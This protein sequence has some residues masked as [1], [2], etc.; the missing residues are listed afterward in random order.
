MA[1][2]LKPNLTDEEIIAQ[3]D[4]ETPE[5]ARIRIIGE[6]IAAQTIQL[7]LR[8]DNSFSQS[9]TPEEFTD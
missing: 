5:Q 1:E 2:T 3:L 9:K 6:A 7:D 8:H 4:F